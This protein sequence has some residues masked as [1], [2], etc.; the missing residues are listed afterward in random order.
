MTLED[1]ISK[2]I[3][4]KNHKPLHVND[5]LDFIQQNYVQNK[6]TI[7]QYRSLFKELTDRGAM[8]PEYFNDD[9]TYNQ[10]A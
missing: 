1:L 8:K 6:L 2:F 10:N 4:M 9:L 5:L 3:Q 7:D